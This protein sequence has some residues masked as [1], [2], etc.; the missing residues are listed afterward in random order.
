MN[1]KENDFLPI[2]YPLI[3]A[4]ITYKFMKIDL[5]RDFRLALGKH[6]KPDLILASFI[7]GLVQRPCGSWDY[8]SSGLL[9]LPY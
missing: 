5:S 1:I 7:L 4:T 3:P 8:R 6:H 2:L 9:L